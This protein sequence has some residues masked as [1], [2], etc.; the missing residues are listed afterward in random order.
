VLEAGIQKTLLERA[1]GNPLY[2]E[3]FARL[4]G[5]RGQTEDLRLPE[6]IQGLIAARIDGLPPDEKTLLQNA[7]VLG[8]VFWLGAAR[9]L[10]RLEK[11]AA[12]EQLHALERKEFVRRE[13]RASVTGEIEYAF[14][15]LLVRDVAYGQIPRGTRA[16]KHRLAARWIEAL[17]RPEDH[18]ELLAHHY[19]A[20]LELAEAAGV[21]TADLTEP[22]RLALK[23][24]GDRAFA[25]N[26]F[27]VAGRSYSRALEL[28]AEDSADRPE[29]LF[30]RA[31][32]L[33]LSGGRK[34]GTSAR[35]SQGRFGRSRERAAGRAGRRTSRGVLVV[36]P[37]SDL[38]WVAAALN[39]V[40]EVKHAVDRARPAT[41]WADVARAILEG[42]YDEAADTYCEIGSVDDEAHA[43]LRAANELV[44]EGRRAEADAQ[45]QK[46]LAF[47]RSVGAT[48]YLR[49]AE[50]LLAASA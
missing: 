7:A 32:A 18:A 26:A 6:T 1:G 29:L 10:A 4:L 27:P 40:D 25:L 22:A 35:G 33:S 38:A 36:Y 13:R 44:R 8:K 30:R 34:A 21:P 48:S 37:F 15:H 49:E 16:E 39:R 43:R 9:E 17:G 3:E 12:E 46:A 24:A 47:Y 11:R 14:R 42:R 19:V 28:W 23:E 5:E 20:A 31:H 41:R 50:S 45:L 2:A